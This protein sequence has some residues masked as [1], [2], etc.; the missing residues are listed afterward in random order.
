MKKLLTF[1][2]LVGDMRRGNAL[3]EDALEE[4]QEEEEQEEER[5]ERLLWR[6]QGTCLG[7]QVDSID[8]P[9]LDGPPLT[10]G[11]VRAT[12]TVLF[13]LHLEHHPLAPRGAAPAVLVQMIGPWK[14]YYQ[15]N[16]GVPRSPLPD[17]S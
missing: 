17:I 14:E 4:E 11:P 5:E 2:L 8:D 7:S 3:K 13:R 9:G 1:V 6:L 16:F 12:S 15:S 10:K